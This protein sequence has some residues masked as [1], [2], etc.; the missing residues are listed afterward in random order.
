MASNRNTVVYFV[1]Y[2]YFV[3]QISVDASLKCYTCTAVTANS[4]CE[5]HPDEVAGGITNCNKKYCTMQRVEYKS[6]GVV[7]SFYRSCEDNP[8]Y[9]NNI[10]EDD[11][12]R[13]YF[14]ACSKPLCNDGT[15]KT[16]QGSDNGSNGAPPGVTKPPFNNRVLHGNCMK[17]MVAPTL[18][19]AMVVLTLSVWANFK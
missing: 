15:G 17:V 7:A 12:Y 1:L 19:V 18:L 5:L 16:S 6:T 8:V 11:T 14:Y 2:V 10:I 4:D 9:V 13:T 3:N